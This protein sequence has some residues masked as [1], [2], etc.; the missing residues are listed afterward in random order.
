MRLL[1]HTKAPFTLDRSRQY[2]QEGGRMPPGKPRGLWVSVDGEASWEAW[3]RGEGWGEDALAHTTEIVLAPSANL[4]H[5]RTATALDRF[6][7]KYASG[8][9]EGARPVNWSHLAALYDGILIAPYQWSRRLELMWYYG[10]DCASGCIWNLDA[11]VEA[12]ALELSK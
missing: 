12:R 3:C 8:D 5:L 11:I 9:R 10:W 1:H 2:S 6:T 7:D 4:L